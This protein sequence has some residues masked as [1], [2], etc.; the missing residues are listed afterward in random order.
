M[1]EL[2]DLDIPSLGYSK[3][4]SAWLYQGVEGNFLVDPGPACTVPAL[5]DF[6]D[7]RGV[8]RLEW[9][10]LTHIHMDHS[11]GIGHVIERFP[12]AQVICHEKAV[13]HL[14]D[15]G[16]LWEGSLKV[17]GNVA[18]VYGKIKPIHA[19]CILTSEHIGF[20]EGIRVIP[21]PGHALHHQC[22]VFKDWLFCGELFGIMI[23][24]NG[25]IYLRPAT[26]PR[27]D[28]QNWFASMDR[29]A[30]EMSRQICFGHYGKYPD[31]QF[32]WQMAKNQLKLWADVCGRHADDR[33]KD[34][35]MEELIDKDPM[36]ARSRELSAEAYQ[37]ETFFTKNAIEG[38]LQYLSV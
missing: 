27:I 25:H 19:S 28:L 10:L 3:F 37:R 22:F 1:L 4:I 36:Y 16:R 5:F 20:E 35:I 31:G 6:L 30:N 9:I 26:P 8:D 13:A 33:N 15:P 29:I 14:V 12:K 7:Q 23:T 11:G 34:R 2:I 32:I 21:T 17:L 38:I 24:L 18:C